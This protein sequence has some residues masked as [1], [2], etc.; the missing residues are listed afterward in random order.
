MEY[1]GSF[2]LGKDSGFSKNVSGYISKCFSNHKDYPVGI[3]KDIFRNGLA[4]EYFARGGISRDGGRPAVYKEIGGVVLDA[5]SLANDFIESLDKFKQELEEDKYTSRV[6]QA[7]S[8][9]TDKNA[10]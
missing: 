4:H 6:N 3:L 9:I 2:L 8:S 5:E 7:E 10:R 1:L